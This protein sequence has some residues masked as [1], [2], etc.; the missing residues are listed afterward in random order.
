MQA[1]R[2]PRTALTVDEWP[3]IPVWPTW[4]GGR[5]IPMSFDPSLADPFLLLAHHKH[6]FSPGDPLRGPFKAV[7]GALGLPYVGDEGFAMHPHRGIDILTY[8][9]DGSDGFRHRDSLG[10]A[11]VYRGGA[12][13]F[14]RSGRGAMH[15]EYW[16]T[17]SDRT[18]R[19][20]LFQ[21]WIN[22]PAR[23]KADPAAIRY[24]GEAWG[25]PYEERLQHDSGGKATRVRYA[26]DEALLTRAQQG[27]SGALGS[28]PPVSVVHATLEPGAAWAHA[29]P[30]EHT[31]LLYVRRGAALVPADGDAATRV[32]AGRSALF[33]RD[34]DTV[35]L[36]NAAD[37]RPCDVL[38]LSG[39]PLREPVA[40]GGP[41]VMN[42]RDELRQ[43]Y[44]ELQDGTFLDV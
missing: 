25:A 14:M 26:L 18:T 32:Q 5:V 27:G 42:T 41:I 36:R 34:G 28:R 39:A 3:A 38:L 30:A 8:V 15:E 16:E 7:G 40:L 31:A 10:G 11:C 35:A 22:L 20:E 4:G 21:L 19:I 13:Q 1:D 23:Q 17:R 9:L 33:A 37:G 29:V 44:R 43:A 2:K 24:V 12:A 6:S